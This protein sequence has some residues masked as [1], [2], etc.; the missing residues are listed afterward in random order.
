MTNRKRI[1]GIQVNLKELSNY[2]YLKKEVT[3]LERK[4]AQAKKQKLSGEEYFFDR[5]EKA[6]DERQKELLK[7]ENFI[8]TIK[9]SYIRQI[10]RLRFEECLSWSRI[11]GI[12]HTSEDSVK[13]TCYRFMKKQQ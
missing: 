5:L 2:Y 13:H 12:L 1:E 7:L 4:A 3:Y 11:A 9:S 6:K 10:F 8:C